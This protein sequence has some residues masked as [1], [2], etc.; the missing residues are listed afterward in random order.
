[1]P[2]NKRGIAFQSVFSKISLQ[3]GVVAGIGVLLFFLGL[4]SS[5]ILTK[6]LC[7]IITGIAAYYVFDSLHGKKHSPSDNDTPSPAESERNDVE[8]F[9]TDRAKP[10]EEGV[11]ERPGG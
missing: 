7:F 9:R 2:E 3:E 1:M 5:A 10:S 6:L 4:W 11:D 8:N